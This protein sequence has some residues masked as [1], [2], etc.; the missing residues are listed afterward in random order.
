MFLK[1]VIHQA[2]AY[3]DD[4]MTM[5]LEMNYTG[6]LFMKASFLKTIM[7]IR[8]PMINAICLYI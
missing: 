8:Y 3:I 7:K 4:N 1:K 6:Q 5:K 2:I